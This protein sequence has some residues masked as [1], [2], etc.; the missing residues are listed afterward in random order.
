MNLRKRKK[1]PC[2]QKKFLLT[3]HSFCTIKYIVASLLILYNNIKQAC[4][5][6]PQL[7][8]DGSLT[9]RKLDNLMSQTEYSLA[10]TPI[11]DDTAGQTMLGDAITGNHDWINHYDDIVDNGLFLPTDI[12]ITLN[13]SPSLSCRCGS[14]PEEPAILRSCRDQLQGPLGA[15]S[16]WCGSVPHWLDQEG[17][18]QPPICKR[19]PAVQDVYISNNSCRYFLMS[20]TESALVMLWKRRNI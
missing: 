10:V 7:E 6:V 17:R 15:R 9:T 1:N 2:S 20:P 8:V 5:I 13:F 4:L 3:S 19:K 18:S 16:P 12:E 11:Y 14:C